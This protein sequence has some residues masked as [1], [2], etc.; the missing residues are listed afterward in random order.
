MT[1]KHRPHRIISTHITDA[2]WLALCNCGQVV[3]L[4]D[5]KLSIHSETLGGKYVLEWENAE[6]WR[7]PSDRERELLG[8]EL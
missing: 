6:Q 1:H 5:Y 2:S 7:E 4:N 3:Y 8:I